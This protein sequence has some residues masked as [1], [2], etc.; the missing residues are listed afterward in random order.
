LHRERRNAFD[1]SLV[2]RLLEDTAKAWLRT[3]Q[4]AVPAGS[5]VA[6]ADAAQ[7]AAAQL[8]G[9]VVVKALVPAGRRGKSGAVQH[10]SSPE[11]AA[12][13]AGRL[14]G[15]AVG[16]YVVQEVYVEGTV[17]IERELYCAFTF[18]D[19]GPRVMVSA[20]GGMDIEATARAGTGHLVSLPID[21]LRGVPAWHAVDLWRRAGLRC[22]ALRPLAQVTAALCR[23]FLSGDLELLEI[24]PL[25]LDAQ[26]HPIVVGAMVAVDPAALV[27]Q[28]QWRGEDERVRPVHPPSP[29]E[30][31]VAA[32]DAAV[33]GPEAR[34]VEL[35]GDI[36]LLVGGGGAG[37]YQQD[38][39]RA[40]GG[41]P[42]N[43]SVT[44]PTGSDNRKLRATI[45]AILEHPGIRALLV[46]FNFAQM[47]RA[48]IRVDTLVDVLDAKGIDTSRFPIVIRMFGAGEAQARARVAGRTGIHYLPREA[49]LDDAV[50]LVVQL[51]AAR[52][53]QA[54]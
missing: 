32:I 39:M 51:A 27:R 8:G 23:L 20:Q 22:T 53:A 30:R 41:R 2:I 12:S 17:A 45:E 46:G 18:D 40:W 4:I 26:A 42:A 21:P 1:R 35:D 14:L 38:R 3:A 5:T 6:S 10:A 11:E 29:R 13:I 37:L 7:A 36:G 43:H 19:D 44:P 48:D 16:G 28:R 9:D 24:N 34:Y 15:T 33:P 31:K 54:T 52:S 50:R 49:S 25:A 47:A